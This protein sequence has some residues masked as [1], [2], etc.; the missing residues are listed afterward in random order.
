MKNSILKIKTY[1][2]W[3][4][5]GD[6]PAIRSITILDTVVHFVDKI[7]AVLGTERTLLQNVCD[8]KEQS[9]WPVAQLLTVP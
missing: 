3:L 7:D 8:G 6:H 2:R 1:N 5:C 4:Q 9:I